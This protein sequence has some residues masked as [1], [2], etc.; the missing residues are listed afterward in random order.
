MKRMGIL[1]SPNVENLMNSQNSQ[2]IFD[3]ESRGERHK[4]PI[5]NFFYQTNEDK[6]LKLILNLIDPN[7]IQ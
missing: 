1:S 5:K 4:S 3:S 7:K 6:N 2:N